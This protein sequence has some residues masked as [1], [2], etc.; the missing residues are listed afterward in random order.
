M[1]VIKYFPNLSGIYSFGLSKVSKS[2][3]ETV[4]IM[5]FAF[6]IKLSQCSSS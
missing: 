3:F 4:S 6:L 2:T 1:I 5:K